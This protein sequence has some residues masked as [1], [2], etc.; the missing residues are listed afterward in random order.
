MLPAP[1]KFLNFSHMKERDEISIEQK[2]KE[3]AVINFVSK[4]AQEAILDPN[5]PE[6]FKDEVVD[7]AVGKILKI[8]EKRNN[9]NIRHKTVYQAK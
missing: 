3:D 2:S 4:Q 1:L 5:L 8:A 9:Y 7:A 6:F